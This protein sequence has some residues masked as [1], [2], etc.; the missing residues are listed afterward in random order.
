MIRFPKIPVGLGMAIPKMRLRDYARFSEQCLKSN[1]AITPDNC[2]VK[3][4]SEALI[5]KSFRFSM[6]RS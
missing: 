5:K 2:L 1:S 4:N 3:R 6:R